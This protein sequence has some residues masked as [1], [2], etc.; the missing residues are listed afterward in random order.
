MTFNLKASLRN[1]I[2][3]ADSRRI[4]NN[5]QIP[6]V[7]YSGTGNGSNNIN[8][9]VDAK[10]LEQQ[11][12]KGNIFTTTVEIELDGKKIKAIPHKIELHPVTDKP[13]HVD[14]VEFTK[15]Q[16]VKAKPKLKFTNQDKSPGL[17]KG[18]F[19]HIVL[20][21]IEV[22]CPADSIPETIEID[23][24]RAQVGSKIKS[25]NLTLPANVKLAK[26]G[27]FIV[28][29]IIGRGSKDEEAAATTTEGA[30][31]P[32]AGA[33]APA[34]GA[35]KVPAAGAAKAPAADKKDAKKK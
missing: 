25:D 7:I 2:G 17:K 29:S 35:A 8:I 34:A 16:T 10:D 12:F 33:A 20:R 13:I 18:G 28:A 30:A 23:V 5:G 4:R 26:K 6:A 9:A 27:S 14:F 1:K 24:G 19:L 32:A 21:K 22:L 11:Y 15:N 3:S 31:A